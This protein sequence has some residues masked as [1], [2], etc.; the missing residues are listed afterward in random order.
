M[1]NIYP[2][3]CFFQSHFQVLYRQKIFKD[4]KKNEA[5]RSGNNGKA[6]AP[7]GDWAV[8]VRGGGGGSNQ[9]RF[10]YMHYF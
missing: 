6:L 7:L 1:E 8:E 5:S 3:V 4:N 10:I 2:N 9:F